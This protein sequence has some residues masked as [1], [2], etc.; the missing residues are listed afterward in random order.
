MLMRE[1][2]NGLIKPREEGGA[3]GEKMRGRTNGVKLNLNDGHTHR[4]IQQRHR[5]VHTLNDV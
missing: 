1:I 3:E 4:Q 2:N 5:H